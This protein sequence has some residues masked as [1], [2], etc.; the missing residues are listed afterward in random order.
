MTCAEKGRR[1]RFDWNGHESDQCINCGA[2]R[3]DV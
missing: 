1:C 3:A 2:W